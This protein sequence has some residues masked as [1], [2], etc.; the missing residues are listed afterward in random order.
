MSTH[1]R[2]TC[3][4][5][6]GDLAVI[7]EEERAA[8]DLEAL[9]DDAGGQNQLEQEAELKELRGFYADRANLEESYVTMSQVSTSPQRSITDPWDSQ[10]NESEES[11]GKT[12]RQW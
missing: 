8:A 11:E 4:D 5:P 7:P 2:N 9:L 3:T 12:K 10:N 1:N 6:V